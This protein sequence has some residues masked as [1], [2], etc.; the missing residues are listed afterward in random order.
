MWSLYSYLLFIGLRYTIL[1]D[2]DVDVDVDGIFRNL[3]KER[4]KDGRKEGRKKYMF[5]YHFTSFHFI[6]VP[7]RKRERGWKGRE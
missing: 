1:V 2:V 4:R 3:G 7:A 6:C 5:H